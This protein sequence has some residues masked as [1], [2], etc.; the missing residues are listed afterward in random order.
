MALDKLCFEVSCNLQVRRKMSVPLVKLGYLLVRTLSK[1]IA[2]VVQG[3]AAQHPSFRSVCVKMSQSYHR[4]EVRLRSRASD[5][6]KIASE[7]IRP[8][9]EEK[10]IQLGGGQ[11][12]HIHS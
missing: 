5:G 2:R 8:L 10:A 9:G 3:Q 7:D 6:G 12:R 1:P 11:T 4:M